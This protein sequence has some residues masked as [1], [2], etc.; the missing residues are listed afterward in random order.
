[1][2]TCHPCSTIGITSTKGVEGPLY[3]RMVARLDEIEV[4]ERER[5]RTLS[6]SHEGVK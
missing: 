1:M 5:E 3:E 6:V 2:C 4:R